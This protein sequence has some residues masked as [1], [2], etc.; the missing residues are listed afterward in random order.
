MGT[1][2]EYRDG[3]KPIKVLEIQKQRPLLNIYS[4]IGLPIEKGKAFVTKDIKIQI[5]DIDEQRAAP[6]GRQ[7]GQAKVLCGENETTLIIPSLQHNIR[8]PLN[9]DENDI[10]D[11]DNETAMSREAER[12]A[13]Q[14]NKLMQISVENSYIAKSFGIIKTGKL[15]DNDGGGAFDYGMSHIQVSSK[16]YGDTGFD[17]M[18]FIGDVLADI[19]ADRILIP[20][21]DVKLFKASIVDCGG[22]SCDGKG[23]IKPDKKSGN[24]NEDGYILVGYHEDTGTPI[25]AIK[26][27]VK[28]KVIDASTGESKWEEVSLLESG[29]MLFAR[30]NTIIPAFGGLQ[31]VKNG[32]SVPAKIKWRVFKEVDKDKGLLDA[33]L[34]TGLTPILPSSKQIRLATG[35][36]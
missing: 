15:P 36:K 8:Q 3:S 30:P 13:I 5:E 32:Y 6:T 2:V 17:V 14:K 19:D 4:L 28:E 20:Y 25:Y 27:R 24:L 12:K 26:G 10:C 1:I 7:F 22:N 34:Q 18:E 29:M 31:V 21:E 33:R 23:F 9:F 11:A 16:K 35:L